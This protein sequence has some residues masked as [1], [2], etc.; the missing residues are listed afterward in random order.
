MEILKSNPTGNYSRSIRPDQPAEASLA[1]SIEMSARSVDSEL[2]SPAIEPR[3]RTNWWSLCACDSGDNTNAP[4]SLDGDWSGANVRPGSENRAKQYGGL[5]GRWESLLFPWC[6]TG[7]GETGLSTSLF[8]LSAVHGVKQKAWQPLKVSTDEGNRIR[9]KN[10][11]S[12]SLLI[13]AIEHRG[14]DPLDPVI[15]EAGGRV[16]DAWKGP[17]HGQ[18]SHEKRIHETTRHSDSVKH[19]VGDYSPSEP[20]TRG[21]VCINRARTGLWERGRVTGRSTQTLLYTTRYLE[22]CLVADFSDE[23][24]SCC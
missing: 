21:T 5:L 23:S 10:K 4:N 16:M 12:L 8:T 24:V 17:T 15:S 22:D 11:G 18:Q 20:I 19:R 1:S 14:T 13:V 9:E 2:Q 6:T 7:T 3:K